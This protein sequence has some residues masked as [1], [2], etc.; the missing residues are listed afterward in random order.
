[1]TGI[2]P[3]VIHLPAAPSPPFHIQARSW[4]SL[5]RLL[6]TLDSTRLEASVEALAVLKEEARLRT[7][8]QFNKVDYSQ[9]DWRV[10]IYLTLDHALPPSARGVHKYTNGDTTTLPYSYTLC[11]PP[12]RMQNGD[13]SQFFT[14]PQTATSPLPTLPLGISNL[15]LYLQSV[16]ED[17]RRVMNDVSGGSRRL[18]KMVETYYPGEMRATAPEEEGS[19][20]GS[21]MKRL[22]GG[23]RKPKDR[24]RGA[25]EETYDLVTPFRLDDY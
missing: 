8:I 12:V 16:L 17:S 5:L 11:K 13:T 14:V 25:N 19:R 6:A 23:W 1:M 7:V 20:E 22:F 24:G 18:A 3:D 9:S 2:I 21:T 15:A 10:V 4:R